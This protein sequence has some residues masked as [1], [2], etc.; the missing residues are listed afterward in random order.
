MPIFTLRALCDI[1]E[2]MIPQVSVIVPT[3]NEK[4]SITPL[5]E[6][7]HTALQDFVYEIVFVDDNSPDG[8]GQ[9][10]QDLMSRFPIQY[11]SRQG[12]K[13]LASAILQGFGAARGIY[14]GAINA[15]LQHPPEAL[16]AL[17]QSLQEGSDIAVA[18]RYTEGG[19]IRGWDWGRRS[20]SWGATALARLLLP[21]IRSVRDPLSGYYML[22]KKVIPPVDHKVPGFKILLEILMQ[23]EYKKVTEVPY[24]FV[25]REYGKSKLGFRQTLEFLWQI[26]GW[27]KKS[28]E[29]VRFLKFLAVGGTGILINMGVLYAL[30]EGA[31]WYYLLSSVIAIET[32]IL[33]NFFLNDHFTFSSLVSGSSEKK[34]IRLLKYNL[35][36]LGGMAFNVGLLWLFTSVFGVYYLISNLIGIVSVTVLRYLVHLNWTWK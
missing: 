34:R 31:G 16:K 23:R 19:G 9:L 1:G 13:G 6:R 36:S 25:P 27:L 28:G 33:S 10:I 18:S 35:V 8:T 30:T 7:I 22:R 32:A 17:V 29:M 14:I 26:A 2:A 24:V 3:Y 12:K 15:D 11:I 21:R 5:V 4:E 20:V